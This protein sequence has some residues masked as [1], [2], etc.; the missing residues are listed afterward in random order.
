MMLK[1]P[2]GVLPV[3]AALALVAI[4]AGGGA[5][6]PNVDVSQRLGNESEEAIAVNPTDPQNIVVVTNIQEGFSGLF[7]GIS[8]DGGQTWTQKIIATGDTIGGGSDGLGDSCCDPSL[9]F[10]QYGNLF[11]SYLYNL[12]NVVPVALSTD[13]GLNFHVIANIP[14]PPKLPGTKGPSRHGEYRFV[15]QET[16]VTGEGSVW[17][18]YN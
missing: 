17:L 3:L 8:F 15:D 5:V 11:V 7:E 6:P 2:L 16:I 12:E 4:P 1:R 14:K 10:D 18:V 13:G 9:S